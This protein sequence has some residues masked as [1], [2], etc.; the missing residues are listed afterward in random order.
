MLS[1]TLYDM[2]GVAPPEIL[3]GYTQSKIEGESFGCFDHRSQFSAPSASS[4][5]LRCSVSVRFYHQGWLANTLHPPL[6]GWSRVRSGRV[7]VPYR[8]ADDRTQSHNVA[9]KYPDRLEAMKG[10][11]FYNAGVYS[12]LPL[13]DRSA[14]EILEL[15]TGP[16]HH[17]RGTDTFTTPTL[18][19]SPN[20]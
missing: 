17:R 1:P 2:L 3:K 13:D 9:D 14:M 18:P 5:S 4:G 15:P 11:W 6:S 20:R 8:L 12:G 16:N 10:L 7:E 19:T